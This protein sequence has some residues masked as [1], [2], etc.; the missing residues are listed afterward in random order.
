MALNNMAQNKSSFILYSDIITTVEKLPDE[1]AG[2]LFKHILN[3]VNDNDPELDD[4]LLEIA[5][6]P[7]K[8]SLRRDLKKYEHRQET[9]RLNGLKGGRPQ[10]QTKAK[11]S[12]KTQSVNLKAKKPVSVSVSDSVIVSA[13]VSEDQ[14]TICENSS[15]ISTPCSK[16]IKIPYQEIVNLYHAEMP[17]H[18]RIEKL[19]PT[20]KSYIKRLWLDV[21]D[22]GLPDFDHW[23][24]FFAFVKQ[25]PFLTGQTQSHDRRPFIPNLEWLI[26]PKNYLKITERQYHD[27]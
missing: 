22:I 10:N 15:E 8:Q 14:K 25:S 7:I 26:K 24:S 16:P 6:E 13:S 17:L 20:R 27:G 1:S 23:K 12:E 3:Y 11:E 18:P 19:D 4:L 5:F 2:K 9:A 21:D